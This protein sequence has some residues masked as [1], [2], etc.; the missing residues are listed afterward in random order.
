[1]PK[2]DPHP[3]FTVWTPDTVAECMNGVF[4]SPDALYE[5]LWALVPSSKSYDVEDNGPA[6]VVGIGALAESWHLV[7]DAQA[8]TLNDLAA[9]HEAKMASW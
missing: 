6:D 4:S 7:T 1:M 2:P 9:K 8:L 3:L 5:A